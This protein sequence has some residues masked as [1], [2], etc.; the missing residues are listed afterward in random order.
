MGAEKSGSVRKS[1]P[2]RGQEL[3]PACPALAL[4]L[5][6]GRQAVSSD[7]G[8]ADAAPGDG[9]TAW[10][11]YGFLPDSPFGPQLLLCLGLHPLSGNMSM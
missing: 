9:L 8:S 2:Q 11:S 7:T 3:S 5:G 1:Q 4:P 6:V 10:L